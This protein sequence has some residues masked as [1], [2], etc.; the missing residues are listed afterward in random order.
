MDAS[1]NLRQRSAAGC[2]AII[3]H[4]SWKTVSTTV[5]V[6]NCA[7]RPKPDCHNEAIPDITGTQPDGSAA[8]KTAGRRKLPQGR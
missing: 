5:M 4:I 7:A 8:L 1:L 6:D 3:A 2:R